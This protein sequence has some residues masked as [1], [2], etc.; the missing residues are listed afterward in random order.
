MKTLMI[1][2]FA[3]LFAANIYAQTGYKVGDKAA[4]FSLKNVDG[5]MVS[6]ADFKS[7]KGVIVIFTCNH[8][9]FAKAYEN[10]IIELH[11]AFAGKG[12]PI[13]AINPNDPV[14]VPE[15]SFDEMKKRA[16]EKSFPFKYVFD[17]TQAIA[18]TYGATR[19]PH[20]YLLKNDGGVFH[21][22]YI[23]AIDDNH[24]DANNVKEKYL[25]EAVNALL[26]NA[27]PATEMT[28]AIGCSIKWKK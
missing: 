28:K 27:K 21:V 18:K 11:K 15:D 14:E 2:T 26:K 3:L 24:S 12:V 10:R 1:L 8:C 22:T 9:P 6:L 7:S 4:G 5:S 13:I 17:E 23:G 16:K 20:V 19:T 25:E